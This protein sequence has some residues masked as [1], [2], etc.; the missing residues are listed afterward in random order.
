[1]SV[2]YLQSVTVTLYEFD[3]VFCCE[4]VD[5]FACSLSLV[6]VLNYMEAN[7]VN[8]L[9]DFLLLDILYIIS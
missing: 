4:V 7:V 1:M 6:G 3:L 9:L 5:V 2:I 8:A